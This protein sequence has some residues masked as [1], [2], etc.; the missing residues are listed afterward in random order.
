MYKLFRPATAMTSSVGCQSKCRHFLPKSISSTAMPA[1][2]SD[3]PAGVS[4]CV[5]RGV[6]VGGDMRDELDFACYTRLSLLTI[7]FPSSPKTKKGKKLTFTRALHTLML[8][9]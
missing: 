4:V 3:S 1:I 2:S 7:L 9:S 8:L 5:G 6:K